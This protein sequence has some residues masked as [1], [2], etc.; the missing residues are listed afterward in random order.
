MPSKIVDLFQSFRTI[1]CV[2]PECSNIIRLGDLTLKYEGKTAK[3]WLDKYDSDSAKVDQKFAE[4]E[5]EEE[6]LRKEAIERGR[7][8]VPELVRKCISDDITKLPYNPYD[9][10]ALLH[11]ID[12]VI[13]NGMNEK[14]KVDD[15]VFLSKKIAN[16]E[17]SK[18]RKS[19]E[20]TIDKGNYSWQVARI[21]EGQ[22]EFEK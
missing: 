7:T 3:T 17:L 11:P 12:F 18:I 5:N 9:I 8:Q 4:F 22:I 6:R 13:F 1:L 21:T 19:I 16:P 14:K 2:C 10:K 20:H 15:I